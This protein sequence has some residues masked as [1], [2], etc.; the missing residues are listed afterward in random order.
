MS[1]NPTSDKVGALGD[2]RIASQRGASPL[3]QEFMGA[4]AWILSRWKQGGDCSAPLNYLQ[5]IIEAADH[6]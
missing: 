4:H 6:G 5:K 3:Y 2:F 1:N